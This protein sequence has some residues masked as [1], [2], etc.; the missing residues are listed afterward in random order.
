HT[1]AYQRALTTMNFLY[2]TAAQINGFYYHF[3]NTTTGARDG[4]SELSSV[5]T[6][7]LMAGVVNV[8]QYWAGTPLQ[9]VAMNVFNRVNWPWMQKPNGQFYGA[10]IPDGGGTFSGGYSDFSEAVV[11]YLLGLGSSTHPIARSSWNSWSRTPVVGYAGMTY[12]TATDA[13]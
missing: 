12:V 1:A 3:L 11:L 9:T 2:N 13:A 8:A 5:D 7:E 10:W 6:A 4:S